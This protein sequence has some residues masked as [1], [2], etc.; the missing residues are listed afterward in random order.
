MRY[1]DYVLAVREMMGRGWEEASGGHRSC[2]ITAMNSIDRCDM[3]KCMQLKEHLNKRI[4]L[5]QKDF[6]QILV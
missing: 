4:K 6:T 3:E 2:R 5:L 1:H